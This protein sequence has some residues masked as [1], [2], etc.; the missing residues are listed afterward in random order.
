[1][2]NR[3]LSPGLLADTL[4]TLGGIPK[5]DASRAQ[6]IPFGYTLDPILSEYGFRL[7]TRQFMLVPLPQTNGPVQD[8]IPGLIREGRGRGSDPRTMGPPLT[9]NPAARLIQLAYANH[10]EVKSMTSTAANPALCDFL[11]NIINPA[12]DVGTVPGRGILRTSAPH[13]GT[14]LEL[15]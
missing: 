6:L 10:V 13:A 4:T 15:S 8:V 12:P 11:K 9:S 2:L 5:P 3:N 14:L 7:F 1:M